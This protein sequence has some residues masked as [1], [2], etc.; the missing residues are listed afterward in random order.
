MKFKQSIFAFLT[1]A[2]LTCN[3]GFCFGNE[4]PEMPFKKTLT[5]TTVLFYNAP[6]KDTEAVTKLANSL[7]NYITLQSQAEE[8]VKPLMAT[9]RAFK[10]IV[11]ETTFKNEQDLKQVVD[12]LTKDTDKLASHNIEELQRDKLIKFNASVEPVLG[13][14]KYETILKAAKSYQ[15]QQ[16]ELQKHP[17]FPKLEESMKTLKPLMYAFLKENYN[18]VEQLQKDFNK[19]I[20]QVNIFL[21][22]MQQK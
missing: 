2:A 16:F 6:Q 15:Q 13:S 9:R 4:L 12:Q 11:A 3:T 18:S 17:L 1:V 8:V 22:A 20:D 7:T 21:D 14:T 10:Q 19:P 5:L